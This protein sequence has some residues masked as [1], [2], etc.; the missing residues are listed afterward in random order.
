M[1]NLTKYSKIGLNGFLGRKL[2]L[3]K[4]LSFFVFSV[5]VKCGFLFPNIPLT[6]FSNSC[7]LALFVQDFNCTKKTDKVM[8]FGI[9]I[10]NATIQPSTYYLQFNFCVI[11]FLSLLM[12]SSYLNTSV[13]WPCWPICM[14]HNQTPRFWCLSGQR[15]ILHQFRLLLYFIHKY[16]SS[17]SFSTSHRN[18]IL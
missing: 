6:F 7:T 9:N 1:N 17:S 14:V 18:N 3:F 2:V 5:W 11:I 16:T 4:S 10:L 12:N 13:L 15:A 8:T